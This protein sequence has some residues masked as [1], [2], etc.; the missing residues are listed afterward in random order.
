MNT[1]LVYFQNTPN[2]SGIS[3]I[4][5][6]FSGP[7]TQ[8]VSYLESMLCTGRHPLTMQYDEYFLF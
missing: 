3:F 5:V 2:C 1:E 6:M 8:F 7:S 4:Y